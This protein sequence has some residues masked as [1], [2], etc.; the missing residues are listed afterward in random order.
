[1][2][3]E[4]VP[5]LQ[6]QR[7]LYD[8]PRGWTRFSDYLEL[9][10]GG[11][12]D[13]VLPL[14]GMNPMGKPH[15]A[16]KLDALIALGAEEV[17][18]KAV[19]EAERRLSQVSGELKVGIVIADDAQGA[20]TNRYL[21]ETRHW[22]QNKG[23]VRRNWAT[24]LVWTSEVYSSQEQVREEVLSSIYR[25]LYLKQHGL[26]NT[27]RQMMRQ[28]GFAMAFAGAKQPSLDPEE[29]AYSR[30]VI[31]PYLDS[32]HFPT[33]FACLYGDEAAKSVGYEP[34]GLS[35]RAGYAVA[36]DDALQ[37]DITPEMALC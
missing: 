36:L 5:L 29:L 12:D 8:I 26:A 1:M 3:L 32:E 7:D 4:F 25:I 13:M 28:E 30:E 34:Q 20:W 31:Q 9:M 33:Q 24:V 27:L 18:A 21:T 10:T 14:S 16:A 19:G 22:F 2:K 15:V 17:A 6:M 35:T 23:E 11:T 37:S